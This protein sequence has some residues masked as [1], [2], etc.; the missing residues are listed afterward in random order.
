[1]V[2]NFD[3]LNKI[4][5]CAKNT[6]PL[7]IFFSLD[8][9]RLDTFRQTLNRNL[10]TCTHVS[11]YITNDFALYVGIL[12]VQEFPEIFI[13]TDLDI[14]TQKARLLK[15]RFLPS[16]IKVSMDNFSVVE[17]LRNEKVIAFVPCVGILIVRKCQRTAV[18]LDI[19][20]IFQ[21]TFLQLF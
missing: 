3:G 14:Q 1:M 21:L 9:H 6:E 2:Q 12:E 5:K 11:L 10:T 19:F 17:R 20:Q 15:T 8:F 18:N 7:D 4:P 13:L 16:S